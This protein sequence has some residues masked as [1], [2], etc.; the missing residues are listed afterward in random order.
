M[1]LYEFRKATNSGMAWLTGG[2]IWCQSQ[3]STGMFIMTREKGV[4][5]L[6]PCRQA[7]IVLLR[8]MYKGIFRIIIP[9]QGGSN[10]LQGPPPPP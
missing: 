10:N 5:S 1:P 8:Y 3:D 9:K 2:P 6:T 7:A 4:K